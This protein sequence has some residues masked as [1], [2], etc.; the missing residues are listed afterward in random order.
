MN[1]KFSQEAQE[2]MNERFNHDTIIALA[3]TDGMMPSVRDVNSYYQE[4]AFYVI[5]DA[6]SNKMV[7]IEKNPNVAICGEWFTAHG[8]GKNLGHILDEKNR[9][10]AQ[11]LRNAFAS[12]YSNGHTNE[13]DPDTCILCVQ[14]TDG[15][16][17][18]HGTR[19]DIDFSQN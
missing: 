4:G 12:W 2:I 13:E 8:I 14:L 18:S 7:Q 1:E 5:T 3:T 6:R 10:I 15:V 9:D 17:F 16:L 19:Y 11:K